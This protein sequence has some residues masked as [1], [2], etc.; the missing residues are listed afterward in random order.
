MNNKRPL[1]RAL[2]LA[3]ALAIAGPVIAQSAAKDPKPAATP[4]QRQ[5]LET[6]RAELDK[7]AERVAELSRKYGASADGGDDST[8]IWIERQEMRKPVVGV[9]LSPDST[10]GVRI[11][12]VTPDG[13]AAAAGLKSGDRLLAIDGHTLLGSD[14][15]T[16]VANARKLL[17]D[18]DEK[19]SVKLDYERDGRRS[20]TSLKPR[21]G[22]HMVF[23][24]EMSG[25]PGDG[26]DVRVVRM[27]KDGKGVATDN[28]YG[29]LPAIAPDVRRE[30]IRIGPH[31][32]CKGQDCDFPVL[33][34]ALR[35][36][37][38]NLASVE[39]KLGRYFGTDRGV[40]VLSSSTELPGLQSGDVI[41]SID[42][43]PVATPR[44][45]MDTLRGRKTGSQVKVDYLRDRKAA[46]TQITVPKP[47]QWRIPPPPP[48]PPLPPA[49]PKPPKPS[50]AVD[51][52][53]LAPQVVERQKIVF[54]DEDGKIHTWEGD[55][56]A[57]PPPPPPAP[58]VPPPPA[59]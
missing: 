38:L 24:P 13:A 16:R 17:G 48:A 1:A 10:A 50:V 11:A 26:H 45:A 20:T 33:A 52:K 53:V 31:G 42:G 30:V 9:L 2:S 36:N 4:A 32:D 59:H 37:G 29:M 44:E 46:S 21:P 54:V 18:L 39:P 41:R 55:G 35:W 7:A 56:R 43:K 34:E 25:A 14:G 23:L 40:L 8:A 19:T 12:G 5:Q 58:P 15:D 49:P 27:R 3:L 22:E 28:V 51:G 57:P 47:M 6:A